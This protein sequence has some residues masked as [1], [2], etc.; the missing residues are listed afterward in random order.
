MDNIV[1]DAA[2]DVGVSSMIKAAKP[3][4][5]SGSVLCSVRSAMKNFDGPG[6]TPKMVKGRTTTMASLDTCKY[7][8]DN[9]PGP[10][11]VMWRSTQGN[12]F[13]ESLTQ[14]VAA[15]HVQGVEDNVVEGVAQAAEAAEVEQEVAETK[16]STLKKAFRTLNIDGSVRIDE[17]SGKASVMD[18]I[19]LLSPGVSLDNARKMLSR[20][21]EKDEVTELE[22]RGQLSGPQT[23]SPIMCTTSRSTEKGGLPRA[24]RS[25]RRQSA[26]VITRVLGGDVSLCGEIEQRCARLGS[27]SEGRSN[28]AFMSGENGTEE[29][30]AKRTR[31][32]PEIMEFAT[33]EQYEKYIKAGL[34]QEM[35]NIQQAIVKSEISLVMSLKEAFEKIQPLEPRQKIELSDR[36]SDVQKRYFRGGEESAMPVRDVRAITSSSTPAEN[37]VVVATA[38]D[39]G[40]G[41]PTPN[42]SRDVRGAEVSIAMIATEMGVSVGGRGGLVGKN[43]KALYAE[44][45]GQNAA[46]NIPKRKNTVYQGRPFKENMYFTRDRDLV[47]R[48]IRMVVSM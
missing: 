25:F 14:H 12:S 21:L 6:L 2:G 24:A 39:P 42:C 43:I 5:H 20:L 18:V 26:E 23:H 44:R 7:I 32:G 16:G 31:V 34:Q 28:Q 37:A 45:Y 15:T 46:N 29:Q 36:L 8:L 10:R 27:T 9:M 11:W 17:A 1:V 13:K 47:E 19:R 4:L 41:T 38:V 48:A 22:Q 30:P 35:V 33:E 40:H 3:E